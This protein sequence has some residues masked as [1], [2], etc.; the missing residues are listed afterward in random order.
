MYVL[1]QY[2]FKCFAYPTKLSCVSYIID[3]CT[4]AIENVR[5]MHAVITNQ[6]ADILHFN[7]NVVTVTIRISVIFTFVIKLL[8]KF[9]AEFFKI[10]YDKIY[11]YLMEK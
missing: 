9:K 8:K 10:T 6:I 5:N 7:D 2:K 4:V 11:P 3:F 1:G